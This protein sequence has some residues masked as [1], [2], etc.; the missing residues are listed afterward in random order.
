MDMRPCIAMLFEGVEGAR[1]MADRAQFLKRIADWLRAGYPSGVPTD[2]YIPL[3]ALLR[4]QLTDAEVEEISRELIRESPPPPEPISP[5]DAGV[6][7]TKVTQE[8]PHEADIDRVRRHLESL[9]WPLGDEPLGHGPG[10]GDDEDN[11]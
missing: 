3:V 2:D 8:L 5:I 11:H 7:I 4:R 9:G 10:P 1:V 6:E